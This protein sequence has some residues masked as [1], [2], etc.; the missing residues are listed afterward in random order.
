MLKQKIFRGLS[1][2]IALVIILK[3]LHSITISFDYHFSW[4]MYN[5]SWVPE[6][7]LIQFEDKQ[8]SYTRAQLQ[9]QY[10]GLKELLPYGVSALRLICRTIP[11]SNSATRFFDGSKTTVKC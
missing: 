1:A 2:L 10:S 8:R 11:G 7:Y 6:S 9:S 4:S 5:G 3:P